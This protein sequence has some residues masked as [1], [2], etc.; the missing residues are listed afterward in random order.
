MLQKCGRET[1]R[2]LSRLL[3]RPS[4]FCEARYVRHLVSQQKSAIVPHLC[5]IGFGGLA[6]FD[7][8][9]FAGLSDYDVKVP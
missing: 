4:T 6:P 5:P 1:H 8:L 9:S 7:H 2:R 3:T